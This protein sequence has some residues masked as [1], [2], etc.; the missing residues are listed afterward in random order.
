M[1]ETNIQQIKVLDS[2]SPIARAGIAAALIVALVFGWTA[3]RR[4]LGNMLAELTSPVDSGAKNV[5]RVAVDFAPNDPSANWLFVNTHNSGINAASEIN[6]ERVVKLSPADFRWWIE[7]G[8]DREQAGD[9]VKAEKALQKA[10]ELAPNYVFPRWQLGNF[11]LRQNRSGEAFNELAKVAE[12]NSLY[13][14]Q[15]FS[16]AWE[17]FE[18]DTTRIEQI[19]GSAPDSR[20]ALAKFYAGRGRAEDSLR[21]WNTLSAEE[22]Q[23][24]ASGARIIAQALY[25]KGFLRA[26]LEFVR[27]LEI[28]PDAK[29]ET[30]QNGGFEKPI[31]EAKD[32]YFGWKVS[33]VEK[34]DVK[35]DST[36][37]YEG[38]RSLRVT[39]SGYSQPALYGIYQAITVEPK[40]K[41]RLSFRLR[42]ENLK[43]GGAPNLEIYDPNGSKHIA[44]S[45]PFPAGTN[46]WQPVKIEFTAPENAEAVGIRTTRV[47]CGA[48]CPIVGT[49]W[50]DDF[51]LERLK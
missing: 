28:E 40:T 13:R 32:A 11:Y 44:S 8:R 17:Y 36:Q 25:E 41:Y 10:V 27:Q 26:A 9:V 46:D 43:S 45:Q 6:L 21:V 34:M 39:F 5:A 47:S 16:I 4:Q 33:P 1:P 18:Q 23:A 19:A 24:N 35:L 2:R 37:K 51:K 50:Y 49:F 7:F 30:V 20:A 15:V 42:T 31:G 3:I 38:N 29:A 12:S 48:D 22:K 14:E